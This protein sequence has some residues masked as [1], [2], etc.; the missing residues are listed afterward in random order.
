METRAPKGSLKVLH[1]PSLDETV[2]GNMVMADDYGIEMQRLMISEIPEG[3]SGITEACFRA[4]VRVDV[5]RQKSMCMEK[6]LCNTKTKGCAKLR[7]LWRRSSQNYLFRAL[8]LR[9]VDSNQ[10]GKVLLL[11][12]VQTDEKLCH[13]QL[14]Y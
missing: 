11:F 6:R 14:I 5:A 3:S 12:L 1:Q 8:Q 9:R 10:V 7:A 4:K 2:I 13:P